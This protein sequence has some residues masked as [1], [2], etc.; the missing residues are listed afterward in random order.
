MRESRTSG[1]V[2]GAMGNHSSYSDPK[3]RGGQIRKL[4]KFLWAIQLIT[5]SLRQPVVKN[6]G[7]FSVMSTSSSR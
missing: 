6:S 3:G 1:S 4:Q 5:S 2:E 7:P